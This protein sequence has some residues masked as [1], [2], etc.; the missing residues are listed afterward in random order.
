M[1]LAIHTIKPSK[2]SK[3]GMKRV[4]RGNASGHGTYSTRGGKG[5]TARSGG[6]H[7]LH[8]KAFKR[9]MQSTPKLGGF[10][11]LAVKP[12]EIYLYDLDKKFKDG[13][14]VNLTV[15][16]D[17]KIISINSSAAKIVLKGTLTKK[18]TVEGLKCTKG[19]KEAIEKVGGEIK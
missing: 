4:G 7:R 15:L 16:K 12:I 17:K 6:S 2:G 14:T 1:T 10:K 8:T 19:A 13:E 9:M 11:S 5:Q 3:R 18:L